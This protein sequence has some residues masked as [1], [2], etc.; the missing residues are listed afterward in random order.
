[1]ATIHKSRGAQRELVAQFI[2]TYADSA[3][4]TASTEAVPVLQAFN[5]TSG[6]TYDVI[7]LPTNAII[8]GGWLSV[9]TAFNTTGTATLSI[10][11]SSSA[12]RYLGATTLKT[13]AVTSITPTGYVNTGAL[14]I[15]ITLSLADTAAT[16]GAF[17][18]VIRYITS[19][20]VDEVERSFRNKTS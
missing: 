3:Y 6:T 12:T 5:A 15:R 9:D 14:P 4:S 16:A 13:A 10:G 18:L 20:R 11:D 1:M 7:G 17:S 2:A 8:T 19:G